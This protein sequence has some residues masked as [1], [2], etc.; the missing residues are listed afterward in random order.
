MNPA[1]RVIRFT[2]EKPVP[3]PNFSVVTAFNP[4]GKVVEDEINEREDRKL[5]GAILD[6][7]EK[8]I[9]ITGMSHDGS[10]WEHG[11][12]VLDADSA[13]TLGKQFHQEAIYRIEEGTLLLV[14]LSSGHTEDLGQ[15]SDHLL[16]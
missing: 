8:P 3:F 7:G 6:L 5:Y 9:Q 15:W 11:W 16:D 12:T 1:Y 13:V 2:T 4:F 14:D 10:H